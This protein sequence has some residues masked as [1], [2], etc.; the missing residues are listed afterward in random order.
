[1]NKP[2]GLTSKEAAQTFC[3]TKVPE[4]FPHAGK[5]KNEFKIGRMEEIPDRFKLKVLKQLL[6]QSPTACTEP[7]A[8]QL[9]PPQ[10]ETGCL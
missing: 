7:L 1:M 9:F 10:Q 3:K 5:K 2:H 6:L 4:L 8:G